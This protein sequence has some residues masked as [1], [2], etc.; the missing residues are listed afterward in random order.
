MTKY[1]LKILFQFYFDNLKIWFSHYFKG[2]FQIFNFSAIQKWQMIFQIICFFTLKMHPLN[3][4]IFI[5]SFQQGL[6]FLYKYLNFCFLDSN[7]LR[8]LNL[9]YYNNFWIF[10]HKDPC[11]AMNYYRIFYLRAPFRIM[12]F[13]KAFLG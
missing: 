10:H 5:G 1:Y 6:L 13:T 7:C 9:I 12:F 11:F 8:E 4:N 2:I 3:R